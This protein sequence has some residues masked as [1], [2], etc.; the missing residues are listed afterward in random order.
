MSD[1][2]IITCW[3]SYIF[4]KKKP[5]VCIAATWSRVNTRG[6]CFSR[7]INGRSHAAKNGS[8]G[9]L[10]RGEGSAFLHIHY[11]NKSSFFFSFFFVVGLNEGLFFLN[12]GALFLTDCHNKKIGLLFVF[13]TRR[14]SP[15]MTILNSLPR[16]PFFLCP[17]I[18]LRMIRLVAH[19]SMALYFFVYNEITLECFF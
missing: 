3:L 13:T 16:P 11:S 14:Q 4:E 8:N 17:K 18:W 19:F 12:F 7:L 15:L 10:R 2:F 9:R 1:E 5:F 6:L